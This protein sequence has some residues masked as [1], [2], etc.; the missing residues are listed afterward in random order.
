MNQQTNSSGWNTVLPKKSATQYVVA[1]AKVV[2]PP[3][4]DP[5]TPLQTTKN[6]KLAFY[7]EVKLTG[8]EILVL[9]FNMR[10]RK[11][12]IFKNDLRNYFTEHLGLKSKPRLLLLEKD[13]ANYR[14][15][16]N[17]L[18]EGFT[19]KRPNVEAEFA[20]HFIGKSA[21][22]W[23]DPFHVFDQYQ[24]EGLV[25]ENSRYL[26]EM[27][28]TIYPRGNEELEG[29]MNDLS[30]AKQHE[31]NGI[32]KKIDKVI[33]DLVAG[34]ARGLAYRVNQFAR[35]VEEELPIKVVYV[36]KECESEEEKEYIDLFI[37]T[38]LDGIRFDEFKSITFIQC[39]P[40][41]L[42]E[43]LVE[44]YKRKSEELE[45]VDSKEKEELQGKLSEMAKLVRKVATKLSDSEKEVFQKLVSAF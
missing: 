5:I 16:N 15:Y 17:A 3:Q 22:K 7:D 8:K 21:L 13:V 28:S 27:K 26:L 37:E 29:L 35:N 25:S 43:S 12:M 44:K 4:E 10:Q 2:N 11:D 31:K 32:R 19:K 6:K 34:Q 14:H 38:F 42:K 20:G 45:N 23:S 41:C 18:K 24:Y 39:E 1:K 9:D 36:L 40:E 30:R 33:K